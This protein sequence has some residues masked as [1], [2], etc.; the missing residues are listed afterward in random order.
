[1]KVV[2][3]HIEPKLSVV[4]SGKLVNNGESKRVNHDMMEKKQFN[5]LLTETAAVL[6]KV[7]IIIFVS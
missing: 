2:Q 5:D 4:P 7:R 1:M 3:S 6:R